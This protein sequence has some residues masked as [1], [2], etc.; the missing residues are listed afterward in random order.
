V[1]VLLVDD[2][3][4]AREGLRLLLA[5][6]ADIRVVG[7][8]AD[9]TAAVAAITA[10][11]P[12][13]VFLDINM[14]GLDGLD[15]V[16]SIGPDK[17]PQV[18]FLTAYAQHAV[19]AFAFNAL[20]YLLKPVSVQRFRASL[21]RARAQLQS[22]NDANRQQQLTQLLRQLSVKKPNNDERIMIRTTG[23]VFFLKP[24]EIIWVEA[25]RDYVSIHTPGKSHL[26]RETMKHMEETLSARGFQ[27]IHRGSLVNLAAIR[28]LLTSDSGDYDVVLQEGTRLKLSRAYRDEL[29]QRLRANAP[30]SGH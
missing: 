4:L 8:C 23:H 30:G 14:P 12:D 24:A 2:E 5:P 6:E 16:R 13:L 7:E 18:I 22:R 25:E 20:D 27:R 19:D 11:Q 17:M 21:E 10:Q 15:V 26:V 1:K 29:L 9:G 28:E 3:P